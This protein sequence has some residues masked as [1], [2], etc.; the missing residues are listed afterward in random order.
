M[1]ELAHRG[2]VLTSINSTAKWFI[3][4]HLSMPVRSGF[5]FCLLQGMMGA[6]QYRV[7]WQELL[8]LG[9]LIL[10]DFHVWLNTQTVKPLTCVNFFI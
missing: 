7:R 4:V 10:H 3:V 1:A 9:N 5:H 8:L 2:L 6:C